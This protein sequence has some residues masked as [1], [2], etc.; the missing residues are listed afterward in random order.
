MEAYVTTVQVVLDP[1]KIGPDAP[2]EWHN[3]AAVADWM[4]ALLSENED[5]L[6]WR[7]M[8]KVRATDIFVGV[9]EIDPMG[10]PV[11]RI[12]ID[13]DKY[14]EGDFMALVDAQ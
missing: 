9:D 1:R 13:P 3:A 5:V 10:A 11:E 7:Y 6:D 4:S 12:T 14:E 8:D 2:T